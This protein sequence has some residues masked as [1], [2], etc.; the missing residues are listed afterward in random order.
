[1]RMFV[2]AKH[3]DVVDVAVGRGVGHF[4]SVVKNA[5]QMSR[6][7]GGCWVGVITPLQEPKV[8][9]TTNLLLTL[10]T[11][12]VSTFPPGIME[13]RPSLF[14]IFIVSTRSSLPP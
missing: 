13:L 1:M 9:D 7:A 8:L 4:F 3:K 11:Q 14:S 12:L 5:V 6:A 2:D 10:L